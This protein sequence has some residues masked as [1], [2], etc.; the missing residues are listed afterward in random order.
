M[1][2]KHLAYPTIFGSFFAAGLAMGFAYLPTASAPG[3]ELAI[4]PSYELQDAQP[5]EQLNVLLIGVEEV[6]SPETRLMSIWLVVIPPD[7]RELT[8]MPI[9]PQAASAQ[10][11]S[12]A[13]PHEPVWVDART[14]ASA[15]VVRLLAEQG[16]WW[17]ETALMDETGLMLL[18]DLLGGAG[19]YY[20]ELSVLLS[21]GAPRA[22]DNPQAA[23]AAQSVL[24]RTICE[25]SSSFGGLLNPGSFIPP[26]PAH[27]LTSA[28]EVDLFAELF[29]LSTSITGFGCQFPALD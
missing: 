21:A 14:P 12:Y 27:F 13:S 8:F 5:R 25:R 16:T 24:L 28:N 11:Q 26:S 10:D 18:L 22:W 15:T 1:K 7:G 19:S 23:L 6:G 20:Q 2:F 4:A 29:K 9:Y 3:P 17:D